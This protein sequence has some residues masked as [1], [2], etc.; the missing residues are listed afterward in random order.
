M[1]FCGLTQVQELPASAGRRSTRYL[2]HTRASGVAASQASHVHCVGLQGIGYLL[3][4]GPIFVILAGLRKID[5]ARWVL[6]AFVIS[7]AVMVLAYLF[8]LAKDCTRNEPA[9]PH[10]Q[11]ARPPKKT[12]SFTDP[13][14]D[15]E[16]A[17]PVPRSGATDATA[18]GGGSVAPDNLKFYAAAG[19]GDKRAAKRKNPRARPPDR[20]G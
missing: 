4:F 2:G 17:S 6:M 5:A 7:A 10:Q 19:A 12:G 1:P 20:R 15:L 3:M 8:L 18:K 13:R 16:M 11:R 14:S 9:V